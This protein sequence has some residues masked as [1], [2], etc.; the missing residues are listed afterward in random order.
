MTTIS[1]S[2]S[3]TTTQMSYYRGKEYRNID[4]VCAI[5]ELL[6]EFK[7]SIDLFP[8]RRDKVEVSAW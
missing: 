1:S 4:N 5:R 6:L 2:N 8:K 7:F 3:H